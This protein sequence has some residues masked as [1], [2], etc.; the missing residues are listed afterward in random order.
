MIL[1]P[2]SPK[3]S[4]ITDFSPALFR[5]ESPCH[6]FL[7]GAYFLTA[8]PYL[9]SKLFHSCR[10]LVSNQMLY[11]VKGQ[12]TFDPFRESKIALISQSSQFLFRLSSFGTFFFEK[13]VT[14]WLTGTLLLRPKLPRFQ[15]TTLR[16]LTTHA[17]PFLG[18][19]HRLDRGDNRERF[20][21]FILRLSEAG[22]FSSTHSIVVVLNY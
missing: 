16:H 1:W 12:I 7:F 10:Q 22:I 9:L 11:T 6:S 15:E 19:M 4:V 14:Q 18:R 17:S 21:L 2:S 3:G 13:S 8:L 20:D 5:R